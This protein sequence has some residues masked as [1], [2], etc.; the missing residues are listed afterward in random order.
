[1]PS[2]KA[3]RI[4]VLPLHLAFQAMFALRRFA[5]QGSCRLYG[6]RAVGQSTPCLGLVIVRPLARP[7][8]RAGGPGG[9]APRE[10][11]KKGKYKY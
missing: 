6:A 9:A 10:E 2:L 11:E 4:K 7:P 5:V 3:L 8:A 1:M